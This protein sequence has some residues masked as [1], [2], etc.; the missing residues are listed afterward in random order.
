MDP[1]LR[2][3]NKRDKFNKKAERVLDLLV[4]TFYRPE[5]V[6]I[7]EILKRHAV[8]VPYAVCNGRAPALIGPPPAP[9]CINSH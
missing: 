6:A 3:R 7:V 5:Q 1:E 2:V 9:A 8:C 4:H